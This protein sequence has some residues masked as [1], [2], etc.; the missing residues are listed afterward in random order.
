LVILLPGYS[1]ELKI[2]GIDTHTNEFVTRSFSSTII[3]MIS[4]LD[5]IPSDIETVEI[6]VKRTA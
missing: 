6:I 4:S 5:G 1:I 3:G 2:N